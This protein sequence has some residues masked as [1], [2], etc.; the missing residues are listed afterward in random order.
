MIFDE[1]A[2]SNLFFK[3]AKSTSFTSL[4][5]MNGKFNTTYLSGYSTQ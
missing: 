5:A 4:G 2:K 1:R 3:S